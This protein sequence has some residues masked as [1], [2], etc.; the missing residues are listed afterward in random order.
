MKSGLG[1]WDAATALIEESDAIEPAPQIDGYFSSVP[2]RAARIGLA[3]H[4]GDIDGARRELARAMSLRPLLTAA[5]PAGRR[6]VPPRI[7][8]RPSRGR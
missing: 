4:R 6:D 2:A 8:P 3:I 1:A 5:G 7:R